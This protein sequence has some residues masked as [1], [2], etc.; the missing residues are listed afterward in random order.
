MPSRNGEFR[1]PQEVIDACLNR[2]LN[3]QGPIFRGLTICRRLSPA[4]SETPAPTPTSIEDLETPPQLYATRVVGQEVWK[5]EVLL[6]EGG[7]AIGYVQRRRRVSLGLA[8]GTVKNEDSSI[9]WDSERM[10]GT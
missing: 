10:A 7:D 3:W 5:A 2:R 8:M 4:I 9:N 6:T 1:V